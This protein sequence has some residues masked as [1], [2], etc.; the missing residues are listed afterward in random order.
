MRILFVGVNARYINPTS[1]LIPPLLKTIADT[2]FFGPGF[3]GDDV[4]QRGVAAFYERQGPFDLV[5]TTTQFAALSD[6]DATLDF[7]RRYSLY[8]GGAFPFAAFM[9]DVRNF[10]CRMGGI[11]LC[12]VM[13]LDTYAVRNDLLEQLTEAASHF[14]GPG[15][16]FSKPNEE[17]PLFDLEPDY[18]RKTA[19]RPVGLWHQFVT[20]CRER[21]IN[22][23]HFVGPHEFHFLPLSLR[24]YSASVAGQ[25]YY[26][27]RN[28]LEALRACRTLRIAPT[29][30]RAVFSSLDKFGMSP[31][32]RRYVHL[33]YNA[34]FVRILSDSR[35]GVTDGGGHEVAIRK[36]FE[37]PASGSLLLARP[38]AGFEALGFE[39]GRTAVI[40]N[41]VDPAGQVLALLREPD[42]MQHIAT[43]GQNVVWDKHSL[44]ARA[45]QMKASVESIV[46]GRFRGSFWQHGEFHITETAAPSAAHIERSASHEGSVRR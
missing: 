24:T 40:L 21:F 42:R 19:T 37:V 35:I 10:L 43:A 44:H 31:Y 46:A 13:D 3:V 39:D 11:R 8:R 22:L 18:R 41:E 30:Y 45:E 38:C 32:A 17:L 34:V 20:T 36:F 26:A 9:T 25:P 14:V 12:F 33:L 29:R 4:L 7:Y 16:G 27:R 1:S 5:A 23:A 6:P 15:E 28:A 2:V